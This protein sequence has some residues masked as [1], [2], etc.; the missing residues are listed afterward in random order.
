MMES[1]RITKGDLITCCTCNKLEKIIGFDG[2]CGGGSHEYKLKLRCGHYI[3]TR[4][5]SL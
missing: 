3:R 4:D 1:F 5:D 2:S